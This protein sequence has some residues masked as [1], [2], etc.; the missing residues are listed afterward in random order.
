ML[1]PGIL[2]FNF[3]FQPSSSQVPATICSSFYSCFDQGP[4][5]HV[6]PSNPDC[7]P[8]DED[9]DEERLQAPLS[10][11]RVEQL[12]VL[13]GVIESWLRNQNAYQKAHTILMYSGRAWHRTQA[14]LLA[15]NT[16]LI[17]TPS[18][19]LSYRKKNFFRK[20]KRT[21]LIHLVPILQIL[22]ILQDLR[23]TSALLA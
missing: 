15:C 2:L 17:Y 1:N 6:C 11:N 22:A 9:H 18:S 19:F 7:H 12:L 13:D 10:Y 14:T 5:W 16:R 4:H 20:E 23:A 8:H 3:G 21:L